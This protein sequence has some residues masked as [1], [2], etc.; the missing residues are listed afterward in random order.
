GGDA[1]Q[2]SRTHY[3]TMNFLSAM[4][5]GGIFERYPNLRFGAIEFGASWFGAFAEGLDIWAHSCRRTTSKYLTMTPS[6]YL[7]RNVRVTPFHFEPVDMYLERHPNLIDCYCY[8]TDYPH[9]EGGKDSKATWI[10][11]IGR[12]GDDVVRKVFVEN[13]EFL[14]PD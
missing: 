3:H 7:A 8:S 2:L 10:K 4:V 5:L 9:V 12:L 1:F 13:G 14:L 11:K 6:E